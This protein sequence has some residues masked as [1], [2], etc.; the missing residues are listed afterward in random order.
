[1]RGPGF[2]Y[3]VVVAGASAAGLRAAGLLAEAGCRTAVFDRRTGADEDA[4]RTWIVTPHIDEVLGRRPR[5]A[6]VHETTVMRLSSPAVTTDVE[7]SRPDLIVERA[8]LFASLGRAAAR[9]GADLRFDRRVERVREAGSGLDVRLRNGGDP[10][11]VRARHVVGADGVRSTVARSAGLSHPDTV[12]LVQALVRLPPDWD[13]RVTGV[14]FRPGETPFFYW[15]IPQSRDRGALGL[16]ADARGDAREL[17]D[18]FLARRGLRPLDYQASLVALHRPGR[19][20][21][22]RLAGGRS[23]VLLVGDAAGHVKVTTVGGVVPGLWGAAAAARAL[24]EGTSYF[25]ELG[26]LRRELYLHDAIRW[27]MNRFGRREYDV[28]LRL[29]NDPL[30][31]LLRRQERDRMAPETMRMLTAQPRLLSLAATSLLRP[32]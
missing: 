27:V 25:G 4:E 28:L 20:L 3:D 17:L 13:P 9:A 32:T 7:L 12:P 21:E 11:S 14:W 1:M 16:I 18:D 2:D 29:L 19:R 31:R 6:V 10:I 26:E 23:R 8:R 22:A 30:R 15:L 5:E 24:R